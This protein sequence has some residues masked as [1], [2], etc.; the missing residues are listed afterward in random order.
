MRIK[1]LLVLTVAALLSVAAYCEPVSSV[2][3][4]YHSQALKIGMLAVEVG[5]PE[6]T[7][8][9]TDPYRGEQVLKRVYADGLTWISH[10][11]REF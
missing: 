4:F 10:T 8:E 11:P 5:R 3:L 6:S 1:R 9:E 7:T 2:F